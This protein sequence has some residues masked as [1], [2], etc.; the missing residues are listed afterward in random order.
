MNAA[1]AKRIE[2]MKKQ[3]IGVEVEMYGISRAKAARIAAG[4]IFMCLANIP[5][6]IY[7]IS[8]KEY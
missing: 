2:E 7:N 5:F 3:T 4:V 6:V 8:R 1:T